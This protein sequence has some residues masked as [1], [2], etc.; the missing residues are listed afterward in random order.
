MVTGNPA[1][2]NREEGVPVAVEP[3]GRGFPEG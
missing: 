1:T 2:M 3:E